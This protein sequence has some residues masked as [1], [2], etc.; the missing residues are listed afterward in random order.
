MKAYTPHSECSFDY[1]D[2]MAKI[3]A[4]LTEHGQV[5]V[6]PKTIER[7]YRNFSDTYAAGW[8]DVDD[9][10]LEEFANWLSEVEV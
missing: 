3:M 5:N 8:M 2:D 4:Y 6:H 9:D 10:R 7:L 1:P